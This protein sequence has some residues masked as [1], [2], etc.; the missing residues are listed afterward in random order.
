[1]IESLPFSLH[2]SFDRLRVADAGCGCWFGCFRSLLL[3]PSLLFAPMLLPA[4][5]FDVAC[6]SG[7]GDAVAFDHRC[8]FWHGLGLTMLLMRSM[9]LF[10]LVVVV[11]VV[12]A[13]AVGSVAVVLDEVADVS[14]LQSPWWY[15]DVK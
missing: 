1:M 5:V 15:E 3:F 8:C 4:S 2:G 7:V 14:V 13:I 6:C 12:A 9:R 11:V 10:R